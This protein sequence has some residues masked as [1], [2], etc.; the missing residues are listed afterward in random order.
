MAD[1]S[2]IEWTEATWN[3]VTG[4]TKI[5]SGCDHCYA[6]RFSVEDGG[7]IKRPGALDALLAWYRSE[8]E[9]TF[10]FV[11]QP[12]LIKNTRGGPLYYLLWAGPN[13]AGLKGANYIMKMGEK[14]ARQR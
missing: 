13:E 11:S 9:K 2:S 5:T 10:G 4:C 1:G 7:S 3:P 6:E 14:P 8:L 12:R